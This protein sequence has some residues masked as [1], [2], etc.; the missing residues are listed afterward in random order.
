MSVT[1]GQLRHLLRELGFHSTELPNDW[2]A[3]QHDHT[4]ILLPA[5]ADLQS[6]RTTDHVTARKLLVEN[7]YVSSE[8][9]DH[10]VAVKL[11]P[12]AVR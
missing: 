6:A 7:G 8:E 1:L 5:A 9:F 12:S 3:H 11:A 4:L 10:R 2:N